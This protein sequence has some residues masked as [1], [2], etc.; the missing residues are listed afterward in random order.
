MAFHLEEDGNTFGEHFEV[1][2]KL[3]DFFKVLDG[4]MKIQCKKTCRES[5]GCSLLGS[6]KHCAAGSCVQEKGYTGCWEYPDR[7][8]CGKLAFQKRSCGER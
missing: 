7:E 2:K 5:G 1:F 6:V 4:I 8:N 3:P